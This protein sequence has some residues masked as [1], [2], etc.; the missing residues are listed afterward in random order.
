MNDAMRLPI[1][2]EVEIG[3]LTCAHTHSVCSLGFNARQ[4]KEYLAKDLLLVTRGAADA[5]WP[6]E[7]RKGKVSLPCF[8]I[9]RGNTWASK[10][11]MNEEPRCISTST[12]Q[13]G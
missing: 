11:S 5:G 12:R 1:S 2:A 3:T 9:R 13:C 10:R 8:H 7:N 6:P 4:L